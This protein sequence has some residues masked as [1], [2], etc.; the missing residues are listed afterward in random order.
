MRESARTFVPTKSGGSEAISG[1]EYQHHILARKCIE[2][3]ADQSIREIICE[4]DG[5]DGAQ[6]DLNGRYEFIQVKKPKIS[7]KL[8][9]LIYARRKEKSIL[10]LLFR[11][12]SYKEVV[13]VTFLSSG[14]PDT[15]EAC[16]LAGLMNLL[17]LEKEARDTE[18]NLEMENYEEKIYEY[19]AKQEIDRNTVNTGLRLLNINLGLPS[20][21]GIEACNRESLES[22]ISR[23]WGISIDQRIRRFA[24]HEIAKRVREASGKPGMPRSVRTIKRT[25]IVD[26]VELAIGDSPLPESK[27][28]AININE[29][30]LKKANLTTEQLR[31]AL[32]MR[33]RANFTKYELDL[34]R[35]TWRDFEDEIAESWNMLLE[36]SQ[37]LRGIKLWR[38][39]RKMLGELGNK[40][41]QEIPELSNSFAEGVF[42]C[43][44]STC[45][46]DWRS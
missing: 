22:T 24:Y 14:R 7:W 39:L 23:M 9:D 16:S 1:F 8:R 30:L 10:A 28:E 11:K 15:K 25:E 35:N 32:E 29:K 43:M 46:V 5:Q 21:G 13:K 19:L 44:T 38:S 40:W 20:Q 12:I 27:E 45:E 33:C 31:Y 42:F 34:D 6:V 4:E 3:L 36:S 37:E 2:M 41:K 26:I 17:D 18:W